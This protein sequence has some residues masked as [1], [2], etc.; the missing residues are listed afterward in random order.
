[1]YDDSNDGGLHYWST[2]SEQLHKETKM[3]KLS[4]MLP[5]KYLKRSDFPEPELVTIAGIVE[6][7]VALPGEEKRMRWCVKFAE[8]DKLMVLNSTN[9]HVLATVAG[10]DDSDDWEGVKVVVYDDENVSF[11]GKLVGGLRLRAPQ[12][13]AK[14]AAKPARPAAPPAD[15]LDD[16]VPFN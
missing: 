15:D 9:L 3:P 4:E 14:P 5:S 7:N 11:G 6:V 10:S 8:H 16:D 2:I 13:K 1:M 12:R